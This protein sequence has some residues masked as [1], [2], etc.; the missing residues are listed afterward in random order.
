MIK[1]KGD[2]INPY[3]EDHIKA[4][5]LSKHGDVMV[6]IVEVYL[7]GAESRDAVPRGVFLSPEKARALGLEL[8]RMAG[9]VYEV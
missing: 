6:T 3:P 5:P 1:L 4:E 9:G 2:S 8:I 7:T